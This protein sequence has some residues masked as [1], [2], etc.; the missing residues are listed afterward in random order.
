M[1]EDF[2]SAIGALSFVGAILGAALIVS[3]WFFGPW[4]MP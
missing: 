2:K 1:I 4:W 3:S